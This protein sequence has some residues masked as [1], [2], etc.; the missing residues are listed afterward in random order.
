MTTLVRRQ[1]L[2]DLL[3]R[4]AAKMPTQ[5]AIHCGDTAWTWREFDAVVSRLAAGGAAGVTRAIEILADEFDRTLALTGCR[6]VEE[7][8]ADLIA[9]RS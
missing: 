7:L 1:T 2:A 9:M 6:N 3:R 4:T 5:P 8:T